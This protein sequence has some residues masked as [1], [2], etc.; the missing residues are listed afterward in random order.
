MACGYTFP[1]DSPILEAFEQEFL[2]EIVFHTPNSDSCGTINDTLNLKEFIAKLASGEYLYR[3][4]VSVKFNNVVLLPPIPA[5]HN[6]YAQM[7]PDFNF[8]YTQFEFWTAYI[9]ENDSL[10]LF[11]VFKHSDLLQ[12]LHS[13]H[14][15]VD[16]ID[17]FE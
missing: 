10:K 12:L 8:N 4:I 9:Y 2:I 15:T 7:S 14:D 3:N 16:L 13:Q 17:L 1:S 6:M 11:A 5:Y